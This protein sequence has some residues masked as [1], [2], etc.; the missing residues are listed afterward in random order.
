M[1]QLSLCRDLAQHRIPINKYK[2]GCIIT[3]SQTAQIKVDRHHQ[4]VIGDNPST[5]YYVSLFFYSTE[6]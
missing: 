3:H 6:V 5:E 4:Q 2:V 1:E